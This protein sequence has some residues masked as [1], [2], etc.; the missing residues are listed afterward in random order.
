MKTETN[1]RPL[2][3]SV[4]TVWALVTARTDRQRKSPHE[5]FPSQKERKTGRG[6]SVGIATRYGLEGPG[7]ESR[8]GGHIFRTCPDG[9]W[10]PQWV[11]GL[12]PGGKVAGAWR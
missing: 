9:P 4:P 5:A 10:G 11:T 8:W 6:G 1:L 7:I 12:F 3:E 2:L